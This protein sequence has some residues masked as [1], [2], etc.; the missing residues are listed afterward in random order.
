MKPF[1]TILWHSHNLLPNM[2]FTERD[3]SYVV[4]YVVY[5][6]LTRM[7]K[8]YWRQPEHV[9]HFCIS[10]SIPIFLFMSSLQIDPMSILDWL[11]LWLVKTLAPPQGFWLLKWCSPNET[12]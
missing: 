8:L 2:R 12:A 9:S 5:G 7:I 10:C 11:Q 3:I 1:L 4:C 6:I